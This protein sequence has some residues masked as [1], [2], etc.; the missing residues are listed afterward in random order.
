[1][2][3][4]AFLKSLE[5]AGITIQVEDVLDILW[6]AQQDRELTI[7]HALPVPAR[8]TSPPAPSLTTTPGRSQTDVAN[9]EPPKTQPTPQPLPGTAEVYAAGGESRD[10]IKASPVVVPAGHALNRK[11]ALGRAM[12]PFRRRWASSHALELDEHQT[13]EKSAENKTLYPVFRPVAERWFDVDVVLEDDSVILVWQDVMRD[14]CQLL[15]ETGAFRNVRRWRL[16]LEPRAMLE[17]GGARSPV[18]SLAGGTRRL[19]S[20]LPLTARPGTGPMAAMAACSKT[21][22]VSALSC[23]CSS[24]LS[25][26]GSAPHSAS[27]P[28]T[29]PLWSRV[30]PPR[31][32]R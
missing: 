3:L 11:L 22:R 2:T 23:S 29:A 8:T 7:H 31:N 25:I 14:F 6:L 4:E 18:S 12:R 17:S 21:G 28:V 5:A 1:V 9:A 26:A 32:C 20:S 16:R 27:L 13:V 30:S 19:V 15:H 24:S 10:S